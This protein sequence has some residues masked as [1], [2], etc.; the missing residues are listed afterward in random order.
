MKNNP[1]KKNATL[2]KRTEQGIAASGGSK[3]PK[4]IKDKLKKA[5]TTKNK[6]G[7]KI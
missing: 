3:T 7:K 1:I 5:L 6:P 4:G 2:D